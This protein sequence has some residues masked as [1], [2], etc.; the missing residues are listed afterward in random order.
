MVLPA[1]GEEVPLARIK[2]ICAFYGLNDLWR[3]IERDP[4]PRPFK[5][6]GCTGWFDDWKGISLYPAGFLHDLK[7]WAG[8][9]GED[10]ERLVADAELMID[11]ARLLNSTAMAE[12]MFH[13]VR[14]GG[15]EKLRASFSWSFGR[16]T[17]EEEKKKP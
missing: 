4:P 7:Y 13:G 16:Q 5:S 2:E 11:V 10:V 1:M 6:D 8:Y 17:L 12:T 15:N 14:V 9:P 3:K